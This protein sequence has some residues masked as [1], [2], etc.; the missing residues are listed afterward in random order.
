MRRAYVD[1]RFGQIH[2]RR[3]TPSAP[4]KLPLYCL[5]QSP[6]SGLEFD[7][8]MRAIGEDRIAVASDYPGYGFSDAPPHEKDATIDAYAES[9]WQVA[10]ALG[11]ER[12]D[13]F[14]NHTGAKVAAAMAL[15]RPERVGG[16]VMVSAALLTPDERAQFADYFQPIPLDADGTRFREMWA[17]IGKHAG[18]GMTLEMMARSML[19]NMMG[20]EAYEWGHAA[21]FAYDAP[22][23]AA[24]TT[25]PHRIAILNP[26]DELQEATRRAAPLLR[27]GEIVELPEWGHGFLEVRAHEASALVTR[28]LDER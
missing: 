23:Q 21:A 19:Q 1:G 11:H 20:G 8:F 14:G 25:L 27:N 26:G 12:I 10:D 24:L 13:L 7:A 16:I 4:S 18:P 17:R 28:L 3:T 5:H 15:L 9:V 6:K 22:F 2:V